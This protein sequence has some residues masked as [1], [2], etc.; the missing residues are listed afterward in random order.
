VDARTFLGIQPSGDLFHWRLPVR[1]ELTTPGNF[2]FGGCGLG[3]GIIAL[4]AA[5]GR[6]TIW[7]SAQYLSYA[8]KGST[9]DWIVTLATVGRHVTQ[10]RAVATVGGNEILTVNAAMGSDDLP[11]GGVWVTPPNVP[12]PEECPSRELPAAFANT[13]LST[14][15]VRVALGSM[16]TDE[17]LTPA[18]PDS[19]LWA[20]LPGHLEP[21]AATL[22]VFG[23]FVSGGASQPLGKRTMGRSLDNTI[24]VAGLAPTEWVLCDIRM[25]AVTSG[26]G[27]GLAFLWSPDGTLLATASQSMGVR[28]WSGEPIKLS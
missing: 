20:R 10:G 6:P 4:E 8:P 18:G 12:A 21:S 13:I 14:I 22:A 25:H 3:A 23:D 16:F 26:Y 9:V 7:A 24:R 11:Y 5:S 1:P 2:L 17:E 19:A 28:V 27:Q 15:E